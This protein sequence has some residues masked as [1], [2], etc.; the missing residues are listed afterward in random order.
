VLVKPEEMIT[1]AWTG[2]PIPPA[3]QSAFATYYTCIKRL[4]IGV[5]LLLDELAAAGVADNTL[6][7]FVSDNSAG[8]VQGGKTDISDH[9]LR[10]PLITRDPGV[11]APGTVRTEL[12]SMVDILPT[13]LDATQVAT[14]PAT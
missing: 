8:P 9:G 4:D 10:V 7:I 6:I 12:T 14:P 13:I 2:Q 5:R 11:A 3:R 1:N